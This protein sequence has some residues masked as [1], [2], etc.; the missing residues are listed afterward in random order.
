LWPRLLHPPFAEL[1]LHM[2]CPAGDPYCGTGDAAGAASR[3]HCHKGKLVI[4]I[5][6]RHFEGCVQE[7]M[8]SFMASWGATQ[9]DRTAHCWSC[10]VD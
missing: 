3:P 8:C 2:V 1:C 4:P 9:A 7:E 5:I 10:G 6:G